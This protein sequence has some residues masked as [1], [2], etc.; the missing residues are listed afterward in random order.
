MRVH[1][2]DDT[3]YR[4]A[5]QVLIT[6]QKL[7]SWGVVMLTTQRQIWEWEQE[8]NEFSKTRVGPEDT[9]AAEKGVM[10]DIIYPGFFFSPT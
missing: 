2:I 6:Y 1:I 8:Q 7:R 5:Q 4:S 10:F 9:E 3:F